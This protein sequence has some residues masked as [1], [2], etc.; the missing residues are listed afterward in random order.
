MVNIKYEGNDSEGSNRLV[1]R[2]ENEVIEM[3]ER[4]RRSRT[5]LILLTAILVLFMAN[6]VLAADSLLITKVNTTQ[7]MMALTFD[8]G[9]DGGN[10]PI[11]LEI[12]EDYN[13]TST[14]FITGKAAEDHPELIED[15]YDAGHELG[16]HSYS[17]PDFTKLT[18]SQMATELKK[19]DDLIIGITGESTKPYFRP[20]Y[21]YLNA[22]VLA[23]VGSAGYTKTI[24]WT[25]D[26]IDWRGDSVA[27]I[28]SR[29]MNNAGNGAIVLMHVGEGAVNTPA[30]LP[31]IIADL[32]SQGYE[33]VTLTELLAEATGITYIVKSG[34]TLSTIAA[35][36]D[37]TVQA[38]A[39]ANNIT[40]VNYIYVGQAL[41]I[42]T[43]DTEPEPPAETYYTVKSGDTL[44]AIAQKFDVTIQAIADANNITN[45]NYIYVGQVLKIPTGTT[46]EPTPE[47]TPTPETTYTVKS[48][49]T[50]SVIAQKYDVTVQA[51]ATENNI[52]NINLIYVGQ[53]LVIPGTT[54]E[55]TPT[56][57]VTYTVKSGD[58][59]WAIATNYGV[60]IQAIAV[61]NDI[62]NV[63]YIYVGQVLVIPQ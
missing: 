15:I 37:V 51:I 62:S 11:V 25:V 1:F 49:D 13:V 30:A 53:V 28:T 43:G 24:K 2:L 59:L 52:T 31:G 34:D 20:P 44:W 58:T 42:P 50:L 33:L 29:V 39:D 12:L 5:F 57:D 36:Y 10:I 14:F 45:T 3:I 23:G 38:I 16:N 18:A 8:D 56:P 55:P 21:G 60:T 40:N 17:H 6:P 54:P 32:Q 47:P 27:D 19:C 9:A 61:E 35:K 26:T 4:I 48:G 7:K 46:P 63:N 22:D 41:I